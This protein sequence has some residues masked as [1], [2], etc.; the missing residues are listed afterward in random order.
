MGGGRATRVVGHLCLLIGA[1][2]GSALA[3]TCLIGGGNPVL[4]RVE[5]PRFFPFA[6]L[7]FALDGLGAFFLL[8]VSVVTI[9]AAIYGPAYLRAHAVSSPT[10]VVMGINIFVGSMALVLCAGDAL[11]FL[12][13]WEGMTL[14]SYALVLSDDNAAN[15]HAGLVYIVIAHAG[16]A[17]LMLVFLTL[18]I[19]AGSFDFVAIRRASA[20]L[21]GPERS[22]LFFLVL[23]GLGAKAGIV[24]LHVWLPLAHPAAPSHVSALM[25]GVMLKVAIYG[26]VR[27]GMDLLAPAVGPLPPAWGWALLALGSISAVIGVLYALQQHDLKRLLAFHSVENV[28]IILMGVG[29]AMLLARRGGGADALAALALAAALLHTFN[30]GAFKGLLFLCAGAVQASAHSLNMEEL[31]GLARRMPWTAWPFLI[32]AVAISGLPPL[33]GFVS[34]WLTF[35]ALIL[36]G[37]QLRSGS[38]L[39]VIAAAAAL[40][41]TGGLAA[42]CFVKAFGVTFLGRPRS[43]HAAE[44]M[45]TA[46]SMRLAMA[47]LAAI[48]VLIGILPGYAMSLL[49]APVTLLLG[50]S[51]PSAL[52]TI[53]GP[54]VLSASGSLGSGTAISMTTAAALFAVVALLAWVAIVAPRAKARRRAPTWTC[55][56]TPQSRFDYTPTAFAKSLRLIFATLYQSKRTISR[57]TGTTP[58][59]LRSLHWK[60]EMVDLSQV[61]FYDRLQGTV[62]R[63]AHAVRKRSTGRIH[64]YIG[65]VL[66]TL[67]LALLV[68]GRG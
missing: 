22:I 55:G 19:H 7:S 45:E 2:A 46:P 34:E 6:D 67:I 5:L 18:A 32:G 30:H 3:I 64:D 50:G 28:G 65:F 37:E 24:P 68:F 27:F 53:R 44:A 47:L 33:N 16:T 31:G 62:T 39:A 15:A 25:S 10:V 13:A 9:V 21:S 8:V 29:M 59:D 17:L 14:A 66:V 61:H 11:M 20:F 38:G 35:Q 51:G 36:G 12:L 42:A 48:C 4:V 41:L 58:Y 52:V 57:Q 60:S 63:L 54:L 23:T 26:I 1:V 40:A 49:D 56:M 43:S